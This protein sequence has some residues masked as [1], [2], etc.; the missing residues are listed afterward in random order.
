M[1]IIA[2]NGVGEVERNPSHATAAVQRFC[3][4]GL[5]FLGLKYCMGLSKRKKIVPIAHALGLQPFVRSIVRVLA[6]CIEFFQKRFLPI[7]IWFHGLESCINCSKTGKVVPN[8]QFFGHEF[9]MGVETQEAASTVH[10]LVQ[11]LEQ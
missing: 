1:T 4:V 2:I 5:W 9:S 8:F 6:S 11:E 10:V 3:M 7:S